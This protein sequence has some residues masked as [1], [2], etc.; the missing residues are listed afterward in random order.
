MPD[1]HH[2]Q[3][4]FAR[5]INDRFALRYAL[6]NHSGD[7]TDA[8]QFG[9]LALELGRHRRIGR[10][11]LDQNNLDVR[12]GKAMLQPLRIARHQALG[13]TIDIV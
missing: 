13:S 9:P 7:I 2:D 8:R 5:C 3:R 10:S 1:H 11:R 4:P 12:S 6:D